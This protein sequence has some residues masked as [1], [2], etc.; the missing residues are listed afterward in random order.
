MLSLELDDE[1]LTGIDGTFDAST[2][3]LTLTGFDWTEDFELALQSVEFRT[4][5]M[6][7]GKSLKVSLSDDNGEIGELVV[8]LNVVKGHTAPKLEL[9][10]LGT[11]YISSSGAV[12]LD[13]ESN[14]VVAEDAN[15]QSITVTLSKTATS[16]AKTSYHTL[17]LPSKALSM[18]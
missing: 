6:T 12:R 14:L 13:T 2:G 18:Q 5:S 15:L 16:L 8:P 11:Y 1:Y 3:V 17:A 4:T 9:S 7:T 10:R